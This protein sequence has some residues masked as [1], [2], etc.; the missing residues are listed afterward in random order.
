MRKIISFGIA[1]M[2]ALVAVATWATATTHSNH[3]T[4]ASAAFGSPINPFE[5]MKSSKELPH[6][7][8]DT[9]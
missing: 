8:Y 4:K 6:Q 5:L 3:Q 7:H 2:L 9:H 1:A